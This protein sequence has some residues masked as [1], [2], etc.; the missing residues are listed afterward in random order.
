MKLIT[1]TL[2]SSIS[3]FSLAAHAKFKLCKQDVTKDKMNVFS[4]D[5]YVS[6]INDEKDA[7]D[8]NGRGKWLFCSLSGGKKCNSESIWF[9][10]EEFAK[11]LVSY[12]KVTCHYTFHNIKLVNRVQETESGFVVYT[13]VEDI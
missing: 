1:F 4:S 8:K 11:L 2:I 10:Q 9:T 13:K 6:K 5:M 3:F 7:L 12:K